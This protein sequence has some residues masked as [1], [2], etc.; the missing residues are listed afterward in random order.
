MALS[1]CSN[2]DLLARFDSRWCAMNLLDDGT[3]P[4]TAQMLDTNSIPGARLQTL[5]SDASEVLMSAASVSARYSVND[6]LTYGGNL[7]INITAGLAFGIILKRRGRAV[8]SNKMISDAANE[9]L[10]Y[11]EQLRRGDRIFALVP[12]VPDAGLP[13]VSP[14][15]VCIPCG[16]IQVTQ[17][18]GRYF[19]MMMPGGC[20]VNPYYPSPPP[21]GPC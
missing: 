18:A 6:L 12:G 5:L 21:C 7:L 17:A 20:G 15:N 10:G 9:A 14:I 19:G 16:G 1:F 2:A 11:L 8:T 13:H 4:T 3:T